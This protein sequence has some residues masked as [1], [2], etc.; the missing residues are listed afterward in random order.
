MEKCGRRLI[1][2][3]LSLMCLVLTKVHT[4]ERQEHSRPSD[5]DPPPPLPECVLLSRYRFGEA[6]RYQSIHLT[7]ADRV[8]GQCP[9]GVGEEKT[10]RTWHVLDGTLTLTFE[11]AHEVVNRTG[12]ELCIALKVPPL[13]MI[14]FSGGN[15]HRRLKTVPYVQDSR[16]KT[17]SPS[18]YVHVTVN[19]RTTK[20]GLGAA[21]TA[22]EGGEV[23]VDARGML[24]GL[25]KDPGLQSLTLTFRAVPSCAKGHLQ[26]QTP[27]QGRYSSLWQ[28]SDKTIAYFM[29]IHYPS[30]AVY[31]PYCAVFEVGRHYLT[32][33]SCNSPMPANYLCEMEFQE[34]EF[35][36]HL[37]I[38][39]PTPSRRASTLSQ[40]TECP[41]NDTTYTF[42]QCNWGSHCYGDG[43]N[44]INQCLREY[45]QV[46]E[47]MFTCT[48]Q[49]QQV[50]Y[51]LV[52]NHRPDC[53]DGSDE[54]FCVQPPCRADDFSCW[55]TKQDLQ[56]GDLNQRQPIFPTRSASHGFPPP[57]QGCTSNPQSWLSSNP[58][59][60][61]AHQLMNLASQLV[62]QFDQSPAMG[63]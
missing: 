7:S 33:S 37:E 38:V 32:V 30:K 60:H 46:G 17:D 24:E 18:P 4:T 48:S 40:M 42:L 39:L 57:P 63:W 56:S 20:V 15:T 2:R 28:W 62:S 49:T 3:L 21:A 8:Y 26:V 61:Y 5:V 16:P 12:P 13:T 44:E 50:H 55:K 58:A 34:K 9:T 59:G 52:C 6:R 25:R 45:P 14:E 11:D 27:K 23:L 41:N 22:V 1:V 35:S 54:D 31:P 47:T 10:E 19:N 29:S 43:E 36:Q 53:T 51:T